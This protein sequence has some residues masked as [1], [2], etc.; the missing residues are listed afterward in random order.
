MGR[1]AEPDGAGAAG[2]G[3]VDPAAVVPGPRR[4]RHRRAAS[5]PADALAGHGHTHGVHGKGGADR[6]GRLLLAA[7]LVPFAVATVLGLILL[8][9]GDRDYPVPPQ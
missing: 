6:R 4:T 5:G 8:W 9:P 1:H 2:S 7:L 3:D